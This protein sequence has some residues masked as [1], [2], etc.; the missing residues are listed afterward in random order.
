MLVYATH[1]GTRDITERMEQFLSQHGFKVAVLKA[2]TV[3]PDRRESWVDERVKQG[4]GIEGTNSELKRAHG[5]EGAVGCGLPS[6]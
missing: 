3:A 6:T 1:T 5:H 4:V 2:D